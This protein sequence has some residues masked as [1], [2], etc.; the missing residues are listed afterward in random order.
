MS[1][2]VPLPLDIKACVHN[3]L[4][5]DLGTGD[6]TAQLLPATACAKA[7]IITREAAVLCGCAWVDAVF[8]QIDP[9]IEV[10]WQ[11][12]D[13]DAVAA[14]Q[15][16]CTLSGSARALLSGERCALNFLQTLSA[17][18]TQTRRYV[19]LLADTH[20][21]LLDTRKTLP[22]LRLAQKYATRCGGAKNHRL[23][24]Y[25]AFLIK[26]NH[27]AACGSITQ[28]IN[29]AHRLDNAKPV[30]VEVESLDQLNEALQAA[31]DIIML[32]NFSLPLMREAV[33]LTQ[34]RAKLEASGGITDDN[35]CQ[36]ATTGIDYISI[37]ALTKHVQAIDLSMRIESDNNA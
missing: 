1:Q 7:T 16:L 23:G 34:G 10:D 33:Q 36:I 19:S 13:G 24:L 11:A 25:D 9:D 12:Q 32:D 5:E 31:A 21:T 37:G 18:A 14:N 22:G 28:A 17:T 8:H 6:I 35:L 29:N 2:I 30:E 27:I 3:A 26:E 15:T 20:V 4:Q